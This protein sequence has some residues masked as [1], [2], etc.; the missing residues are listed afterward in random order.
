[1]GLDAE[2]AMNIYRKIVAHPPERDSDAF[3]NSNAA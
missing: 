2:T 1:M 3:A